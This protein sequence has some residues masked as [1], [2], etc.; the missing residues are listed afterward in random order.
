MNIRNKFLLAVL[1]G[2]ISFFS[3]D[4][5]D[6]HDLNVN[7]QAVNEID[8][9]FMFTA[10]QLGS[11]SG[12]SAGDN[13]YID[14]RTNIGMTAYLIQHLANAGGG[15]APGDKYTENF[16]SSNA[17]FEFFYGDALKNISEVIR[18]TGPG[19]YDEGNKINTRNAA[20]IMRVL[21]FHR[22]TDF[23]GNIPYFGALQGMDGVFFPEYD[24]QSEIYP[25]L[26]QELEEATA[27]MSTSNPDDGFARA[28]IIYDGDITKWK[29]F[30]YSLMLRLAMRVSDVAP[31]LASEYVTK[32]IAGGVMQR[33]DDNAFVPMSEGPSLWINQ[34]GISRAFFP[35][36]GGQPAYMSQTLIDWL[37]AGATTAEEVDP[38]LMILSGGIADWSAVGWTPI[39]TNPLEQKGMPN[40]FDAAGLEELEGGPIDQVS[41]YSRINYLLLQRDSPYM[42]MNYAESAFLQAEA[43]ERGI[44]SGIPGTAEEHYSQ[45]VKEAMQMYT[46]FDASL[47]V[48]DAE[49]TAYLDR[50]PYGVEKPALEMIGEQ[51]WVSKFFNWWEAWSDWRRTGYPELTP[52]NYPGNVTQGQIMRKLRYPAAEVATNE[53]FQAGATLPDIFTT[54]V[55][56]DTAD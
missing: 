40:G 12:G 11:A 15:I 13:R 44:G 54:R 21:N 37:K 7:P 56:W 48:S 31:Q 25:H 1:A 46:Y 47:E 4:T 45:G 19:G 28:D 33:N 30:G 14:W 20:R 38:R 24:P 5:E 42:L 9:N 26:L 17:P 53:N 51:M 34:N 52:T 27:A 50:H 35:G 8:L 55:W 23:Y 10:A 39:N 29:R 22:L 36:D 3:C 32:A 2:S 6:L 43:L 16:E 18:Q 49:V 41:T